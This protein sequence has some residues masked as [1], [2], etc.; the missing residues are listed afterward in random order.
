MSLNSFILPAADSPSDDRVEQISP[1]K[2]KRALEDN[3]LRTKDH[4]AAKRL[5]KEKADQQLFSS[6]T[7]GTQNILFKEGM[8]D[9][10]ARVRLFMLEEE[11]RFK[12]LS[13][14]LKFN[15]IAKRSTFAIQEWYYEL[16]ADCKLPTRYDSFRK[17]FI[18]KCIYKR[19]LSTRRY[20][21]ERWSDF[22]RRLQ[23][24]ADSEK[25]PEEYVFKQLRLEPAPVELR[26]LFYTTNISLEYLL[27]I[28]GDFEKS[29][30]MN[31]V[32]GKTVDKK[33]DTAKNLD[34]VKCYACGGFGHYANNCADKP[35]KSD[36]KHSN[37]SNFNSVEGV[38]KGEISLNGLEYIS[39]FDTASTVNIISRKFA[40]SVANITICY[41]KSPKI[42]KLIDGS[43]IVF[44][45]YALL[46][47]KYKNKAAKDIFYV[48]NEGLADLLIGK[49]L[50]D[51]LKNQAG[52]PVKCTIPTRGDSIVSWS[53]PIKSIHE[54]K[55]FQVLVKD[56]EVR[57]IL[58][59][60]RSMWLNPVVLT[61]KKT[62]AM[63][64]CIDLRRVNELVDLDRFE[65]PLIH[66]VVRSL[67][68]QRYFS[69]IDLKD[70][71]FQ[72]ELCEKY[73]EKTAFLDGAGRL[74]QFRKMPQGYKN[75]P[76]IFQRGMQLILKDLIPSKCIAYIDDI[77][78]FGKDKA[79]H[80]NNLKSVMGRLKEHGMKVNEEKLIYCNSSVNF[81][82]YSISHN[83]ISPLKTRSSGITN[84]PVPSTHKQMR[85][86]LGLLNYDRLFIKN[87]SSKIAP[88]YSVL[89]KG[90][91]NLNLE[92]SIIEV[93]NSVK[94][95]WVDDLELRMPD[96]NEQFVLET[97]AS[98]LGLGAVLKQ[99]KKVMA[100]MS[101]VLKGAE[102]HYS[103]TEKETLAAI[104][105]MEKLEYW[106]IGREFILETDHKA[107]ESIRNK[108]DFGTGRIRRW[109]SRLE[110]FNYKV[111]Y[112][113]CDEMV[114]SDTLLRNCQGE[115]IDDSKVDESAIRKMH[116]ELGHRK[117]IQKNLGDKGIHVSKKS[118]R[119]AL[120]SCEK[121]LQYDVRRYKSGSHITSTFPGE[122]VA[123][124]VLD[125]NKTYKLV[126]AIDYF[127]RKAWGGLYKHKTPNNVRKLLDQVSAE[128]DIKTLLSDNGKGF[129]D[130]LITDWCD[131]KGIKQEFSI[132]YYH[133]GN[134]RIE[135]LNGTIRAAIKKSNG[136][137]ST[138]LAKCLKAYNG[139]YHRALGLT[140]NQA[141]DPNNHSKVVEWAAEYS[142]EF[143]PRNLDKL[144]IGDRVLVRNESLKNKMDKKFSSKGNIVECQDNDGYIVK[145]DDGKAVRRHQT[146]L[147][148]LAG[149]CC[150]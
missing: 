48:I 26:S 87:L 92:K 96:D 76:A 2:G 50:L 37:M 38:E 42:I 36:K 7:Q 122:K 112:R 119:E 27:E 77:L 140:P 128:L 49:S 58:E 43:E 132:P 46:D 90:K 116:I 68:G 124:D 123:V 120:A 29:T 103:I 98:D 105:A 62:G 125:I 138:R 31:K 86:F 53:R 84:F 99:N 18:D 97:D 22:I 139:S 45:Q 88:L 95:L 47:I 12:E 89:E 25:L 30:K 133:Q 101:R 147:K 150:V 71:Y 113:K 141:T 72:V 6:L 67:H 127:T 65:L 78:V 106:L 83:K 146:G 143:K 57:G 110:R 44:K 66:N 80:K 3:D 10:E 131:S 129:S 144:D 56:L 13:P 70:G 52:F 59:E 135:R 21:E 104:W 91:R 1:P 33:V 9:K 32:P 28:V 148:I 108:V 134:G 61:R 114:K 15:V 51:R 69:I 82:G 81:L 130:E 35:S 117:N 100:Y 85:R 20:R 107:L 109:M 64:F 23:L 54:K 137:Y 14:R 142:K 73:R 121:C 149:E 75:S 94:Q 102:K 39:I 17:I 74:M 11:P 34:K 19:A 118:I 145:L 126:M 63:R 16:G 4:T 93:F 60:S 136:P 8:K 24:I 111:V 5:T 40:N 41:P 79:E 55:E 115:G